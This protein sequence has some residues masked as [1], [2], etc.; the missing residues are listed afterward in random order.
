[1]G[2]INGIF[3]DHAATNSVIGL[4]ASALTG[5]SKL[6]FFGLLHNNSTNIVSTQSLL[7]GVSGFSDSATVHVSG[8]YFTDQ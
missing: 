7:A 5:Q 2:S 3:L 4:V 1:M 6:Q 8:T